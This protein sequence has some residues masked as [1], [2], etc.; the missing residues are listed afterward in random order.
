MMCMGHGND[1]L[2]ALAVAALC[3]R[4]PM[5]STCTS[6]QH[7]IQNGSRRGG[8]RIRKVYNYRTYVLIY[9]YNGENLLVGSN[10]SHAH[11]A[12]HACNLKAFTSDGRT[13]KSC[14]RADGG[15]LR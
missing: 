4:L 14:M 10:A 3:A 5:F 9:L 6:P 15:A 11:A 7:E 2:S 1:G 8:V 12:R 13:P